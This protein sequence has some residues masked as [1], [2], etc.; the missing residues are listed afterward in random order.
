MK[1]TVIA[2]LASA[3]II[4][5]ISCQS[6]EQVEFRRYYSAGSLTYINHCQN[7][8]GAKGEGLG[9]LIPPLTDSVYIKNNKDKLAC[10]LKYSLRGKITISGRDYQERMPQSDLPP[11]EMANVLT[12]IANSFGNKSGTINAD[13]VDKDLAN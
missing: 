11:I 10:F 9:A 12:Y 3:V 4:L 13:M 7:C 6:D 5:A 2:V 1:L 8:H